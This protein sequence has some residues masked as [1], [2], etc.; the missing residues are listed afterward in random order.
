ME[1][2][3]IVGGV[4]LFI[5]IVV[6]EFRS[7]MKKSEQEEIQNKLEMDAKL[8]YEMSKPVYKIEFEDVN[9]QIH[10][11]EFFQ[12]WIIS[13]RMHKLLSSL[14]RAAKRLEISMKDGYIQDKNGVVF[15][16]C[17]ILSAKVVQHVEHKL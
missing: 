5:A 3:I 6:W 15:P 14:N 13:Y 11:T 17:N 16:T 12:P 2:L 4:F 8:D 7:E 1:A 9:H 10:E